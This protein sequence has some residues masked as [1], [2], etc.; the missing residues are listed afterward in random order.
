MITRVPVGSTTQIVMVPLDRLNVCRN[1]IRSLYQE[2]VP[3]VSQCGP[4]GGVGWPGGQ[5][6]PKDEILLIQEIQNMLR[7][8][9]EALK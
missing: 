6:K 5:P 9:E 1:Q 4:P 3:N 2:V 7:D 8:I